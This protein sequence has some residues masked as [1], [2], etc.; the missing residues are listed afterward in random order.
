MKYR[1]SSLSWGKKELE[2]SEFAY[3]YLFFGLSS[4]QR[5]GP[6]C[7]YTCWEVSLE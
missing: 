3:F 7:K 4:A 6:L 2:E 1:S 5:T